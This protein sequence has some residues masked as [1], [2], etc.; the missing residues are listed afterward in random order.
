[1][2]GFGGDYSC[3]AIIASDLSA[4][5]LSVATA[6][7]RNNNVIF[8]SL[9]SVIQGD[10]LRCGVYGSEVAIVENAESS[11]VFYSEA[12][13]IDGDDYV[14]AVATNGFDSSVASQLDSYTLVSN[15]S[16][17]E[18]QQY[19]GSKT[20]TAGTYTVNWNSGN[21]QKITLNSDADLTFT[22][23]KNGGQYTLV[24]ENSASYSI[25]GATAS[26]YT[27]KCEGG[28]LPNI[29]NSGT[30]ICVLSVVDNVIYVRHFADFDTP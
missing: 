1:M 11:A 25:T 27:I 13:T 22:N 26:G 14:V 24:V 29:T 19:A 10:A 23:V 16:R 2:I 21:T 8:G 5:D 30:D 15:H 18:G 9:G 12:T 17:S 7:N 20:N 6:G 3:N 4:M 28:V